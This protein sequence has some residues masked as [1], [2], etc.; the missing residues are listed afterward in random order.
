MLIKE[1]I[2]L[3][4]FIESGVYNRKKPIM[5][6]AMNKALANN[7]ICEDKEKHKTPLGA[8]TVI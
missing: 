6:L 3:A 8:G 2:D 7:I 1:K 4:G 5:P